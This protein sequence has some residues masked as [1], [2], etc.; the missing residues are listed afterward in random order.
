MVSCLVDL[1]DGFSVI[2]DPEARVAH[3]NATLFVGANAAYAVAAQAAVVA[4]LAAD[5]D[6]LVVCPSVVAG[7]SLDIVLCL[8]QHLFPCDSAYSIKV[9]IH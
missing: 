6:C 5:F 1:I 2:R 8:G 9:W 4:F 3:P 7:Q